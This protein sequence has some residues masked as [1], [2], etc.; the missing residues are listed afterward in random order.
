MTENNKDENVGSITEPANEFDIKVIKKENEKNV[1]DTFDKSIDQIL[2]TATDLGADLAAVKRELAS[3]MLKDPALLDRFTK[4]VNRKCSGEQQ[5]IKLITT[6]LIARYTKAPW[7]HVSGPSR[8]GKDTLL[9]AVLELF[10]NED[11]I[12]ALRLTKHAIEYLG[13]DE[14]FDL[15]GKIISVSEA[16]GF[17]AAAEV[18]KPLFGQEGKIG[19]TIKGGYG[20]NKPTFKGCPALLNTSIIPNKDEALLKRFWLL[21]IDESPEHT[22]EVQQLSANKF[23]HPYDYAD[24]SNEL[25][26]AK[27]A[28]TIYPKNYKVIIPFATRVRFPSSEVRHRGDYEKFLNLISAVACT[29]QFQRT[30]IIDTEKTTVIAEEQDFTKAM[31]LSKGVLS[32]TLMNLPNH[33]KVFFDALKPAFGNSSDLSVEEIVNQTKKSSDSV[34]SY[35]GVLKKAGLVEKKKTNAVNRYSLSALNMTDATNEIRLL[36]DLFPDEAEN[37][38]KAVVAKLLEKESS[39][40]LVSPDGT[41]KIVQDVPD[42]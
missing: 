33:I 10:P 38:L 7:I 40:K 26:I 25:E 2:K 39:V 18:V 16:E 32:S 17:D 34:R 21:N 13:K 15:D 14:Q 22:K 3:D 5:N 36:L 30:R 24:N 23:E 28:M 27:L 8:G 37:P 29:Y 41:E 11:V 9:R 35:M 12:E 4:L 42:I 20:N 1:A 19:K 31:E 6:L